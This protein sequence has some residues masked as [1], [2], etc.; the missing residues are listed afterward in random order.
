[1]LKAL[2]LIPVILFAC[3]LGCPGQEAGSLSDQQAFAA[4]EKAFINGNWNSDIFEAKPAPRRL[5][6]LDEIPLT[7]FQQDLRTELLEKFGK[8]P[9]TI[10]TY[11]RR[12]A[13]LKTN[14]GEEYC[15]IFFLVFSA[16]KVAVI[17]GRAVSR[18][19]DVLPKKRP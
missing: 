2:A 8:G 9:L 16:N 10:V 7:S 11:N 5:K 14:G 4:A 13:T 19:A 18:P 12:P 17:D 15:S 3:V 6:T 1:M